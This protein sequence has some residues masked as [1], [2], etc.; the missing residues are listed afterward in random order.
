MRNNWHALF[1]LI[2]RLVIAAVF[3]VAALPKIQA[4]DAFAE[5]VAAFRVIGPTASSWV[6]LFLPWVELAIGIGLLTRSLRRCSGGLMLLLLLLF[7]ALHL[8]AWSRGLNLDCGCFGQSEASTTGY[9]DPLLRNCALLLSLTLVMIHDTK[10]AAMAEF[11][12]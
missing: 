2:A 11:S 9:W 3:I 4:P 6:A 8:S 10:R 1:I 5:S 12:N 7:I